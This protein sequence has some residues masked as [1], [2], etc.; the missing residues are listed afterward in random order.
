MRNQS[1]VSILVKVMSL[2]LVE[3]I[4]FF[5]HFSEIRVWYFNSQKFSKSKGFVIKKKKKKCNYR[6]ICWDV[7]FDHKPVKIA[8]NRFWGR[9]TCF[10]ISFCILVDHFLFGQNLFLV[11]ISVQRTFCCIEK[12]YYTLQNIYRMEERTLQTAAMHSVLNI[13]KLCEVQTDK[14]WHGKQHSVKT[15]VGH[16]PKEK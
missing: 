1:R 15:L 10:V 5:P 2:C 14:H 13:T 4:F 8:I 3:V 6:F 16:A 11:S 7:S 9:W 12:L